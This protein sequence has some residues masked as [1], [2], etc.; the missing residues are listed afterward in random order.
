[1]LFGPGA[2]IASADQVKR[3]QQEMERAS[4]E[5]AISLVLGT[6]GYFVELNRGV[7]VDQTVSG[8]AFPLT[9]TVHSDDSETIR[10]NASVIRDIANTARARMGIPAI[11]V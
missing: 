4:G 1:F 7:S 3:W 8:H 9:A 10:G 6:R 5:R 2:G 11:S